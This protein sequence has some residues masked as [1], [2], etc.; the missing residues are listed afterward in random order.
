MWP[1]QRTVDFF[2][3]PLEGPLTLG[4]I[5]YEDVFLRRL[6]VLGAPKICYIKDYQ[7]VNA[8]RGGDD[9]WIRKT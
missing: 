7:V 6:D 4:D 5:S 9:L 8:V 1:E 2:N 3:E